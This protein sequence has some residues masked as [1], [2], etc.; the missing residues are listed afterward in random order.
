MFTI[1][2]QIRS[3]EPGRVEFDLETRFEG[4]VGLTITAKMG[5]VG[6]VFA[7]VEHIAGRLRLGLSFIPSFPYV[8]TLSI[9]FV[10]K[11][12]VGIHIKPLKLGVSFSG[13]NNKGWFFSLSQ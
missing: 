6:S 10:E 2:T 1:Y 7:G 12:S 11:P 13:N 4:Q 9:A 5:V 3:V 8:D